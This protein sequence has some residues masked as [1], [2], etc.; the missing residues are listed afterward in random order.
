MNRSTLLRVLA[1]VFLAAAA[2]N[3]GCIAIAAGVAIAATSGGSSTSRAEAVEKAPIA[4][5]YAA[6]IRALEELEYRV[7]DREG[8]A[9]EARVVARKD[10]AEVKIDLEHRRK[11]STEIRIR[12]AKTKDRKLATSILERIRGHLPAA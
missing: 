11:A 7:T 10:S 3:S 2:L 4:S 6:T 9:D 12:V 5:V 1:S 8:D